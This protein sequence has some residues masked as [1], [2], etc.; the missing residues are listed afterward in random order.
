MHMSDSDDV[1]K[2]QPDSPLSG[3]SYVSLTTWGTNAGGGNGMAHFMDSE[4]FGGNVGHASIAVT[5]PADESGKALVRKY[6]FQEDN[7]NILPFERKEQNIMVGNK[8]QKQDVYTVYFS[9]WPDSDDN[10]S[11]SL[12]QTVNTDNLS[13]RVGVNAGKLNP[14]FTKPDDPNALNPFEERTYHGSLGSKKMNIGIKETI[15]MEGLDDQK[16]AILKLESERSQYQDKLN[17]LS[18]IENKLS[19]EKVKLKG[20]LPKLLEQYIPDWKEMVNTEKNE[21]IKSFSKEDIERLKEEV[22]KINIELVNIIIQI[23][24]KIDH[25]IEKM[26]SPEEMKL[27]E[28]IKN[29]T[30][31]LSYFSKEIQNQMKKEKAGRFSEKAWLEYEINEE[32]NYLQKANMVVN[33]GILYPDFNEVNNKK[34]IIEKLF[35]PPE[36]SNWR[37]FLPAEHRNITATEMTQSLYAEIKKNASL[38]R[39]KSQ[40]KQLELDFERKLLDKNNAFMQGEYERNVTKGSP[41]DNQLFLPVSGINSGQRTKPGLNVEDMLRKMKEIVE[42]D[43]EFN[44]AVNNCSVTT[45]GILA[46][47]AEPELKTYFKRKAW[48]GFGTPQEVFNGAVQYQDVVISN[49]GKKPFLQKV[50]ESN[51]LNAIT[52]LG[53]KITTKFVDPDTSIPARVALGISAI[54]VGVLAGTLQTGKALLTPKKSVENLSQFINYAWNNNSNFLKVLSAPAALLVS[55]LAIPAGLQVIIEKGIVNPVV[56]LAKSSNRS[57]HLESNEMSG[58]PTLDH[59]KLAEVTTHNPK[60]AIKQ[61]NTLLETDPGVIPVLSKKAQKEVT[62]YISSLDPSKPK[63]FA[64]IQKY[65]KTVTH[66]YDRTA[67]LSSEKQQKI[68]H[69][70][71]DDNQKSHQKRKHKSRND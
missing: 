28:E 18:I 11:F 6:C 30:E 20:S 33:L 17:A 65:E 36:L 70:K 41:P 10:A 39:N 51:P 58:T 22:T 3:S 49:K 16:R 32:K 47:G 44:I 21:K 15:H 9:W 37:D 38:A 69:G 64:K 2:K 1:S 71:T 57:S 48:G 43:K 56:N 31:E 46:A 59:T 66:I 19:K 42:S 4:F 13:E 68:S 34:I 45:G 60:E 40:D 24:E 27:Q 12:N 53:G 23:D 5:F 54:P 55:A 61:L 50:E 29:L 63:E 62:K 67:T 8:I 25:A 7:T 26:N 14:K 35:G 52:W